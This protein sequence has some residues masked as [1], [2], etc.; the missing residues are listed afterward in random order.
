MPVQWTRR[1]VQN[2][3]S[4]FNGKSYCKTCFS[5]TCHQFNMAALCHWL[6]QGKHQVL[7]G[8]TLSWLAWCTVLMM[9]I[10][11][12]L[13]YLPPETVNQAQEEANEGGIFNNIEEYNIIGQVAAIVILFAILVDSNMLAGVYFQTRA[14]E[15]LL[16]WLSYYLLIIPAFMVGGGWLAWKMED[17]QQKSW[18]ILPFSVGLFYSCLWVSVYRLYKESINAQ[19]LIM[20]KLADI[21]LQPLTEKFLK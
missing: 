17:L 13:F 20:S 2:R 8:A 5:L 11:F 6:S 16:F 7:V 4:R 15:L 12:V 21:A 19:S 10:P 3:P 9:Y 14:H 1:R 18:S